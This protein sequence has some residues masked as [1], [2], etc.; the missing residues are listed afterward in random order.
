MRSFLLVLTMALAA[1][2]QQPQPY[3]VN[4]V[5]LGSS[6][7]DWK[8][9]AGANCEKWHPVETGVDSY[10][11]PDTTYAGAPVGEMVNFY[12]GR[13]LS[14]YLMASH[15][16]FASLRAA[17]KQKLGQPERT[18]QRVFD[19]DGASR[20]VEVNRWSNGITSLNL[21]EFSPDKDHT[22]I[23]LSHIGLMAEQAKEQKS[24]T[25]GT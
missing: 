5:Q 19:L 9:G 10:A 15:R 14:F 8:R 12:H 22:V 24:Q 11:C 20:E 23:F 13:L 18:E 17:L 6:F 1:Q 16:D 2:S 3:D 7:S 25:G 21:I 4:G